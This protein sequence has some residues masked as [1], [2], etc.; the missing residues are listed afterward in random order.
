[1]KPDPRDLRYLHYVNRR[2]EGQTDEEIARALKFSSVEV[3]WEEFAEERI[4]PNCG[5]RFPAKDHACKK[6][7]KK[8]GRGRKVGGEI[9]ELPDAAGAM[10]LFEAALNKLRRDMAWLEKRKEHL[11]GRRFI[12][13]HELSGELRE[14]VRVYSRESVGPERW[15]AWCEERD[16]NPAVPAHQIPH[17]FD[18]PRTIPTDNPA[19]PL[20]ELITTYVMAYG[21][22]EA[23]VDKLHPPG[24]DRTQRA[25]L[26]KA[27]DGLRRS[28]KLVAAMVRGAPAGQTGPWKRAN[29]ITAAERRLATHIRGLQRQGWT[30][31]MIVARL[32][33]GGYEPLPDGFEPTTEEVKRLAELD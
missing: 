4:C 2:K 7:S 3:M 10:P 16:L 28:A 20:P 11:K 1:M 13:S 25:E 33:N 23:L 17:D 24:Q 6:S 26:G 30:N 29:E 22:C 31:E 21:D 18:S 27:V 5:E 15:E 8:G 14:S 32:Q 9:K 19:W 12:S